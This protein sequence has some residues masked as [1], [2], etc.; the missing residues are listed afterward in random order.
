MIVVRNVFNLKYGKAREA[1][2]YWQEMRKTMKATDPNIATPRL[3]TDLT[4]QAYRLIMES[5]Y[6]S[7][8]DFEKELAKVFENKEW[9][10]M[11]QKFVP[12]VESGHREIFT[13][14]E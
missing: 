13:V 10:E 1:K 7:L 14:V 2:T 4:G 8:S 3:L 11:Y 12:L 5:E 6:K 9:R